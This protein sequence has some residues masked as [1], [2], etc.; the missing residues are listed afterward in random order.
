[1]IEWEG[2]VESAKLVCATSGESLPP[3]AVFYSGLLFQ[4]GLFVRQDFSDQAWSGL[5][6]AAFLGWWRQKVPNPEEAPRFK[7]IDREALLRIFHAL[8]NETDRPKQCFL[9]VVA[10]FLMRCRKFRYI[11]ASSDES[12]RTFVLVEDRALKT[13]YRVRDPGMTPDEEKAVQGNLMDVVTVG[14]SIPEEP[15]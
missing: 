1:M 3:G 11:D 10:L 8:K 4:N 5:D 14:D 9:Y 2:R 7:P 12:G 6:K 13:V 15:L